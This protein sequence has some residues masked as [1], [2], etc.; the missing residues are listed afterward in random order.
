MPDLLYVALAFGGAIASL[1]VWPARSHLAASASLLSA[2]LLSVV[3]IP[4]LVELATV[5]WPVLKVRLVGAV[6]AAGYFWGGV[7]GLKLVPAALAL[8][9]YRLKQKD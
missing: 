6:L 2:T 5:C 9:K 7:L 8:S 1:T 3:T 4:A